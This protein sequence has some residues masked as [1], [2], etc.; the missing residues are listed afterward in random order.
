[1]KILMVCLGNICRSPIAEGILQNKSNI[2]GLNW[3]V[4]SASTN[5]YHTGDAPHYLSQ[6]V[7]KEN[8]IDIS[9]QKS[10]V[11]KA[12]DLV[13]YDLIFAMAKDV[14]IDMQAIAGKFW[15]ANKVKLILPNDDVPDP[16]YGGIDGFYEVYEILN[17]ACEKILK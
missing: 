11:F 6:R 10:R 1:M 5:R 4:D 9:K 12:E 3:Q 15:D 8:G 14:I 13:Y 2:A 7:A 16:Y 17:K